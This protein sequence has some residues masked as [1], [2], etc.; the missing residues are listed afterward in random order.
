MPCPIFFTSSI[1]LSGSGCSE[2]DKLDTLFTKLDVST[3][4]L[5]NNLLQ[6][7]KIT[8]VIMTIA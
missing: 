5:N 7:T 2:M 3:N 8:M 4:E 1:L 6:V